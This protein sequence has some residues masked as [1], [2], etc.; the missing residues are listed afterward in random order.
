MFQQLY[1]KIINIVR[2]GYISLANDDNKDYPSA[3]ITYQGKQNNVLYIFPYGINANPPEQTLVSFFKIG[4]EENLQGTPYTCKE[5]F[6]NLKRGEVVVG[7]PKTRSYVKFLESGDI[8]I[9]TQKNVSI[10]S[11]KIGFYGKSPIGQQTGGA[12]VAGSSYTSNEQ[13]MLNKAYSTLRD[14]G[15]IT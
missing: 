1:N 7:S 8:E 11:S 15:F 14:F 6:K 4:N 5:R 10:N 9:Y 12:L 13:D 3:Q 2:K